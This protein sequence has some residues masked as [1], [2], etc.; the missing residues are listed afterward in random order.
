MTNPV[1][2]DETSPEV[3]GEWSVDHELCTSCGAPPVQAPDLMGLGPN[4][5]GGSPGSS[6]C[7]FRKQPTTQEETARACRAAEVSCCNALRYS[8]SDPAVRA[9]LLAFSRPSSPRRSRL[10]VIEWVAVV[11]A[12]SVILID[13]LKTL[14]W[15]AI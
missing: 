5:K 4:F 13:L 6:Q 7:Y 1:K 8:G 2:I 11:L 10:S 9:R 12:L 3:P 14:R 15:L